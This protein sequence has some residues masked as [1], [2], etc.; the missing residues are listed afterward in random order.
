MEKYRKS[1]KIQNISFV[2]GAL[3]L[4]LLQV[5]ALCGVLTPA[6]PDAHWADFWS[7]MLAGASFAFTAI[8]IY[9]LVKNLRAMRD[10]SK[11][12]KLYAKEHD[13]RTIQIVYNAQA[14]AYRLSLL[15]LLVVALAAGYFNSTVS[16]TCL[17]VVFV[18]A[19]TGV[20]FKLYWHRHL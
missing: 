18:Q 3:C 7:G 1:L 10:E 16:V 12:R 2:I 17:V 19:V 13:E 14:G 6:V 15:A 9:G 8:L 11:L 5:L 20:I 4:I